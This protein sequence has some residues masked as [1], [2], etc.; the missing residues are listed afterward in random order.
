MATESTCPIGTGSSLVEQMPG[1]DMV[2][3]SESQQICK[4]SYG[5]GHFDD[6]AASLT[7]D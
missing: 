4:F 1:K 3:S 2:V 7:Y 6:N 5:P